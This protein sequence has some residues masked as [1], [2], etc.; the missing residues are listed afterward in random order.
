MHQRLV[1]A[2]ITSN[3]L[4]ARFLLLH[5]FLFLPQSGTLSQNIGPI[6][7][8]ECE[9]LDR[10]RSRMQAKA[11]MAAFDFIDEWRFEGTVPDR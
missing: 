2:N 7:P 4:L 11:R 8:D 3:C 9:L 10:R 5:G 6:C 1:P